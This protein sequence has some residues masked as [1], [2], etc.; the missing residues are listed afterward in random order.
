VDINAAG[1]L[2]INQSLLAIIGTSSTT[3][4]T[5]VAFQGNITYNDT[6]GAYAFRVAQAAAGSGTN[7]KAITG[8]NLYAAYLQGFTQYLNGSLAELIV[9]N[10]VLTGPEIA[11][12]EAYLHTKWG[13]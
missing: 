10:R 5:A 3:L 7:I 12:V 8:K 6:T 1:Q 2:Q 11:S 4:T 13:V 9:Y